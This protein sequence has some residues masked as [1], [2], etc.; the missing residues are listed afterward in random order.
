MALRSVAGRV[1]ALARFAASSTSYKLL[2]AALIRGQSVLPQSN[3]HTSPFRFNNNIIQI[4]DNEDF[5]KKVLKNTVPV[6]LDFHATWCGPCKMLGPRLEKIVSDNDGKVILAKVD[7]DEH[8]EI[9][10]EYGVQAVPTVISMK[11]GKVQDTFVGLK[12][13]AALQSFVDKLIA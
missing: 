12:D 3:F 8:S 1:G 6:V 10:M 7:I 9:A 2:P 4:Q 11:G 5:D 13:D